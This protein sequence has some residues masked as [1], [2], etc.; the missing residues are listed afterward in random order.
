MYMYVTKILDQNDY[1]FTSSKVVKTTQYR[2]IQIVY[3]IKRI[4]GN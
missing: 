4:N 1:F 2:D 3:F